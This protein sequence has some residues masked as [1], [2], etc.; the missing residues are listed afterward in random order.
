MKTKDIALDYPIE[1]PPHPR[2]AS[3]KVRRPKVKDELQAKRRAKSDDP[4]EAEI[5]LIAVLTDL[6]PEVVEELDMTDYGKI[7]ARLL[8]F[9]RSAGPT[10]SGA[11][12]V[13]SE[14]PVSASED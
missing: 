13:N 1:L 14:R 3:I 9:R 6:A 11:A 10:S 5:H 7:Q 4:A 12:P 2:I 8:D